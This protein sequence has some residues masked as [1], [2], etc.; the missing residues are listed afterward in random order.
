[1]FLTFLSFYQFMPEDP[2]EENPFFPTAFL[3]KTRLDISN[4][5]PGGGS[6]VT[7]RW[8]DIGI[9]EWQ[10]WCCGGLYFKSLVL[11]VILV[12]FYRLINDWSKA[13]HVTRLYVDYY[14]GIECV[15]KC[16]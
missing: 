6:C 2:E 8:R 7:A 5:F 14:V 12:V 16:M 10:W 9:V 13:I 4:F 3:H 15:D 11:S 1:M